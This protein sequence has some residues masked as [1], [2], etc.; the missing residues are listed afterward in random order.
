MA[1]VER[2]AANTENLNIGRRRR[3]DLGRN[4]AKL[5]RHQADAG[6]VSIGSRIRRPSF[7]RFRR[8]VVN[9]LPIRQDALP[10][11]AVIADAVP[12]RAQYAV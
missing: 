9:K 11:V 8:A 2:A 7:D 6:H 3:L 5:P 10:H 4:V 1:N 12:I